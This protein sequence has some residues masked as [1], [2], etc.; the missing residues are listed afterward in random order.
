MWAQILALLLI[1]HDLEH[2]PSLFSL[3]LSLAPFP[4]LAKGNSPTL[5]VLQASNEV[6]HVQSWWR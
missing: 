6:M 3:K 4:H 1:G 2:V 5:K